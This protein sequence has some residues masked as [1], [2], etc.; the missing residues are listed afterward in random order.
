MSDP[1]LFRL[2]RRALQRSFGRAGG[3]YDAAAQLQREVRDELLDRLPFFRLQPRCILDLGAGTGAAAQLLRRRYVRSQVV[4]IDLAEGMLQA[5]RRRRRFW[6]RFSLLCADARALPLPTHS[7]DL[8]FSNLMLQWCDQPV[9]VFVELQRVLRPGGLLLFSTFGP[10]TLHELRSA[11]GSIDSAPH[12][13]H[14]PDMPQLAGTMSQSGLSEP[15]MDIEARVRHYPTTRAL[16]QEL[17][18]IGAGNA[19]ADRRR[20]LTGKSRLHAMTAAYEALRTTR[21]LPATYEVIYGAAFGGAGTSTA[22][23]SASGETVVPL[24][25]LK[26]R[27]P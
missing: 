24:T 18:A 2:D 11:W 25:S 13:S 4:A 20:A 6:Q 14:F 3:S 12:V 1:Q 27:A 8:I 10:E 9:A 7:V 21:G 22:Q 19:A 15:V 23:M 26:H 16:M 17:R 5:A